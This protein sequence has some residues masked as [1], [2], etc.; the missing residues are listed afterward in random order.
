ME[1]VSINGERYVKAS[2][3]ARELGYTSDYVGQLC[4]DGKVDAERVG[5][6]WFVSE[7]SI[8]EH[9]K[10][11]YRSTRAKSKEAVKEAVAEKQQPSLRPQLHFY[12]KRS[13]T[14]H[15]EPDTEEVLPRLAQKGT[16]EAVNERDDAQE[17]ATYREEQAESAPEAPTEW[18][19]I[20]ERPVTPVPIN[21]YHAPVPHSPRK[22]YAR[23]R[24]EAQLRAQGSP[25]TLYR[26]P[27]RPQEFQHESF[28]GRGSS[29]P[30]AKVVLLLCMIVA[31]GVSVL[32]AGLAQHSVS[33]NDV[34]ATSY[35]F[36]LTPAQNLLFHGSK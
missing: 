26:T 14:S 11:R 13:F 31:T 35:Q 5:R 21:Q 18:S 22:T 36:D 25:S 15:Y 30:G 8:R 1:A 16:P 10:D 34:M 17:E 28:H 20:A 29:R 7:Q 2:S 19:S 9:K 24:A 33:S 6:G 4:R 3:I 23:R 27:L 12:N 32:A